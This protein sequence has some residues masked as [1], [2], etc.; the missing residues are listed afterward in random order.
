MIIR[1]GFTQRIDSFNVA[2]EELLQLTTALSAKDI[3]DYLDNHVAQVYATRKNVLQRLKVPL[4][5]SL[6]EMDPW[7]E[8]HDATESLL[9]EYKD[10]FWLS[11]VLVGR[12]AAATKMRKISLY[13]RLLLYLEDRMI[14]YY[15]EVLE[16]AKLDESYKPVFYETAFILEE[17]TDNMFLIDLM[18]KE[19]PEMM[20]LWTT[21]ERYLDTIEQMHV[22]IQRQRQNDQKTEETKVQSQESACLKRKAD[23]EYVLERNNHVPSTEER[24][25]TKLAS[26]FNHIM[27]IHEKEPDSKI[28]VFSQWGEA[29]AGLGFLLKENKISLVCLKSIQG[30]STGSM[31][32][33][34]NV[35][36][37]IEL[38]AK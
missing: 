17:A 23:L 10:M 1:K 37:N 28:L 4:C 14:R 5:F 21:R 26:V 29:I 30:L 9:R 6:E 32:D 11:D 18:K 3:E 15:N 34:I 24:Y 7:K 12:D 27:K 22:Q 20:N 35:S 36:R 19:I 16:K 38:Q 33:R 13:E 25:G 8:N 2:H 31:A